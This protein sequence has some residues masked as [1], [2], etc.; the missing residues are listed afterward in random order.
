MKKSHSM[1]WRSNDSTVTIVCGMVY[2]GADP[3]LPPR[4]PPPVRAPPPRGRRAGAAAGATGSPALIPAGAT[5]AP[6]A[7]PPSER[8]ASQM[9]SVVCFANPGNCTR[10]MTLLQREQTDVCQTFRE[11]FLK[12]PIV[13][14]FPLALWNFYAPMGPQLSMH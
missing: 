11:G 14:S 4:R 2:S 12:V 1:F 10:V 5:A 8:H 6:W 7:A 13:V 3:A 9:R